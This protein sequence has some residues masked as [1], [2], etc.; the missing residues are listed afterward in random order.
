MDVLMLYRDWLKRIVE[1]MLK[2]LETIV[3]N[4]S[5]YEDGSPVI[6]PCEESL[7]FAYLLLRYIWLALSG[8]DL[9]WLFSSLSSFCS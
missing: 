7:D 8:A 2:R 3:G 1:F 5:M 4:G 6:E 9:S